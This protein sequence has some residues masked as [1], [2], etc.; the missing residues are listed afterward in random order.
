[1]GHGI[2]RH[3]DG[4]IHNN[5]QCHNKSKQ[6]DHVDAATVKP[7]HRQR[8][9]KGNGNAS[10]HPERNPAIEEDIQNAHHQQQAGD[11]VFQQQ[12]D[13][14]N[15]QLVLLIKCD[16]LQ[17][18]GQVAPGIVKPG[19]HD[20]GGFQGIGGFGALKLHQ[21]SRLALVVDFDTVFLGPQLDISD[22]P[23]GQPST[24]RSRYNGHTGKVIGAAALLQAAYFP[25]RLFL[26]DGTGRNV[27]TLA[28]NTLAHG[29]QV[30]GQG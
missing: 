2:L 11:A 13:T 8:T 14:V 26:T 18:P 6:A 9:H 15:D 7:Q 23:Q 28:H 1:M 19:G 12:V 22:V 29:W 30:H 10:G 3:D 16:Q 27:L 4:V 21:N 17:A 5:A 25:H 24:I 20:L